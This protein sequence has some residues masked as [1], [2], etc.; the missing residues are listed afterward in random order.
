M[1]SF[2]SN[3]YQFTSYHRKYPF[4]TRLTDFNLVFADDPN[5]KSFRDTFMQKHFQF[6]TFLLKDAKDKLDWKH[7]LAI[8][9]KSNK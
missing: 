9:V 6:S 7:K 1:K 5:L 4:H 3:R 2:P 8:S